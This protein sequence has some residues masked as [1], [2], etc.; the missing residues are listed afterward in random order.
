MLHVQGE[1]ERQN[2]DYIE[3]Y[4]ALVKSSFLC[5]FSLMNRQNWALHLN[6]C[7]ALLPQSLQKVDHHQILLEFDKETKEKQLNLSHEEFNDETR[8][9]E[10][11][12]EV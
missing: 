3:K 9:K 7:F 10:L 4:Y 2:K 8:F 6:H 5:Q 1:I 11:L 12:C